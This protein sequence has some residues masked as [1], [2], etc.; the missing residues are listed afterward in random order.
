MVKKVSYIPVLLMVCF[1]ILAVHTL[2]NRAL[3][4][5]TSSQTELDVRDSVV[6]IT[7]DCLRRDA[8]ASDLK[9]EY[10]NQM[11]A[12]S[13]WTLPSLAS[14]HSS[15]DL[16]R[17]KVVYGDR[18]LQDANV[19]TLADYFKSEGYRT[20]AFVKS[21]YRL[22]DKH[23][24]GQGFDVRSNTGDD[25]L[26]LIREFIDGGEP[27]FLWVHLFE[28]HIP[29][30]DGEEGRL[31]PYNDGTCQKHLSEMDET[32]YQSRVDAYQTAV[33]KDMAR[34]REIQAMV[35]L[36][37]TIV[38]VT[39]DHGEEFINTSRVG[40]CDHGHSLTPSLL[41]IPLVIH[42]PDGEGLGDGFVSHQ[43][44]SGWI[45]TG[46]GLFEDNTRGGFL[47][48][49]QHATYRVT[50]GGLLVDYPG[51]VYDSVRLEGWSDFYPHSIS[52]NRVEV[53]KQRLEALGYV[54]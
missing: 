43:S 29:Y 34:V 20:G 4:T 52:G 17:H 45:K 47:I 33:D 1:I 27:Y 22:F 12:S 8:I 23:G 41:E 46:H 32:L 14:L 50:D 28:A 37:S 5:H 2:P 15:Q 3:P 30:T 51:G 53:D 19:E 38:V 48:G 21:A 18:G 31:W 49:R 44:L 25:Q 13:G 24:F 35:D 6:L 10:Y 40:G 16:L 42:T 54:L 7:V 26:P 11:Y 9:G 36:S 39:S